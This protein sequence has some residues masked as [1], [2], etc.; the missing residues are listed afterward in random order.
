[1]INKELKK[2][3][4]ENILPY[5]NEN[6]WAH[7]SWHIYEVIR[8]S[9]KLAKSQNTNLDLVYTIAILHDIPNQK[10]QNVIEN[11]SLTHFFTQEEITIIKKTIQDHQIPYQKPDTIYAKI[12]TTAN[13]ITSIKELIRSLE[14][15]YLEFQKEC[16]FEK[17]YEYCIQNIKEK[18]SKKYISYL[19]SEEEEIF[20]KELNYYLEHPYELR[21]IIEKM[22][23]FLRKIYHL[24]KI[25]YNSK[26]YHSIDEELK[27]K[28]KSKVY[29]VS[30]NAG[31]G[32]PNI[33]NGHG[34]I[35]CSNQSG[36]F[37]GNKEE[38]IKTQFYKIQKKLSQ[39]WPNGKYIAYFQAGTNTYAPL[40]KIKEKVESALE[41][42][43]VVGISIATRSDAISKETLDYL[44]ELN[45][46]TD[47]IIELGLQ[48]IHEKTLK[49]I[50]RGHTLKNFE[51]MV[52]ELEKRKINTVVH[53]INGLPNET[54]EMMIDTVKYLNKLP[55]NGIKIHMLHILKNTPLGNNYLKEPIKLLT[56]EEYIQIVC[57]Q[58]EQLN[59]NIIIHR[60]TGDPK[61]EDL[62]APKWLLKKFT[63]LKAIG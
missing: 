10:F 47:L 30:L 38:D 44:E 14:S 48:S 18:Y 36:D 4:K 45:H 3:L 27:K 54:K 31:F 35:F 8:K 6:D 53:I 2:Y 51:N 34:C 19:E 22:D 62:I 63:I 21:H 20:Q 50:N 32:C 58:L 12:L 41:L 39:K 52:Y 56:R 33:K 11:K 7:Q 15:K 42:E 26:P 40:N 28:F 46:R 29:K 17:I 61:K 24:P 49:W 43:N 37:A 1:M 16:S 59:S 5:Y 25:H 55:I 57:D 13:R 23:S 9:L 60:I